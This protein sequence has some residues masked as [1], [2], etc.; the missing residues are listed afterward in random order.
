MGHHFKIQT[1]Q[2]KLDVTKN[3]FYYRTVYKWNKL[4][5]CTVATETIDHFKKALRSVNFEAA[6]TFN[7]HS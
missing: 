6:L 2:F 5:D 4:S 3:Q 7:R 1:S